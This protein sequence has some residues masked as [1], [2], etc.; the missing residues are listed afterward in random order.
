MAH[1][2]ERRAARAAMLAASSQAAAVPLRFAAG[3]YREQERVARQLATVHRKQP[4]SGRLHADVGVVVAHSL[5]LLRYAAEQGP[6]HLAQDAREPIGAGRLRDYWRGDG[7]SSDYLSR[8]L[9]R[10]YVELLALLGIAPDRERRTRGC[11]FCGARPWIASRRPAPEADAALRL[12][13]CALCG[14]DWP[15]GR[16]L[17]AGCGEGD[18]AKL[19][20]FE[21]PS[22]P[23]VRIEACESCRRYVKSIDLTQDA[24]AIS[25]VDDLVSLGMDL[26]A[27]REG[28]T[29][30]EPGLAGI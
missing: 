13:G 11:P 17:C 10:P 30:L 2:F 27:A 12:L 6:A 28:F 18:P 7:E 21:E 4:L 5:E 1:A 15:V 26:W 8:A 9:L 3:L 25:E 29:R 14:N 23:A 19:P 16:I 20:S 24:R 22:H